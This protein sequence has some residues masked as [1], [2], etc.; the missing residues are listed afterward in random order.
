MRRQFYAYIRGEFES[1]LS[2]SKTELTAI[3][4]HLRQGERLLKQLSQPH[5]TQINAPIATVNGSRYQMPNA[6]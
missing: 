5:V 2:I 3:E 1:R 6:L 4:F